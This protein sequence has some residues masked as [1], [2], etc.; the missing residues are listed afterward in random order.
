MNP[1]FHWVSMARSRS[2][3]RNVCV[4]DAE[5]RCRTESSE[6]I[7]V[8]QPVLQL[9][10]IEEPLAIPLAATVKQTVRMKHI[11]ALQW[12]QQ[13]SDSTSWTTIRTRQET[14]SRQSGHRLFSLFPSWV[15][16]TRF[17]F[18]QLLVQGIS[19]VGT[20]R[21]CFARTWFLQDFLLPRLAFHFASMGFTR[22]PTHPAAAR[23][24]SL[25]LLLQEP[26]EHCGPAQRARRQGMLATAAQSTSL[27]LVG[28]HVP[29]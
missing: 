10:H 4:D 16:L 19:G 28:R 6:S 12:P 20:S 21:V 26:S 23:F 25:A 13:L 3:L 17:L 9:E 24:D 22:A 1:R 15:R 29:T 8:Q 5:Q 18:A 14:Q 2:S 7:H 27:F 11:R